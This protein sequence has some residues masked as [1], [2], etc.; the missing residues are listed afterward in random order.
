MNPNLTIVREAVIKAVPEIMELKFGCE[1]LY[2]DVHTRFVDFNDAGLKYYEIFPLVNSNNTVHESEVII[3]GRKIGIA[4]VLVALRKQSEYIGATKAMTE[5]LI[6]QRYIWVLQ[7]Y[8]LLDDDLNHASPET[9]Q[10]LAGL[11]DNT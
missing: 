5:A 2:G 6:E 9:L 10:F 3:L 7:R 11:L 4:D 1:L 8:N